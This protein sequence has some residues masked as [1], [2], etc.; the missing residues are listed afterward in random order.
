MD[1]DHDERVVSARQISRIHEYARVRFPKLKA[2]IVASR[3]CQSDGSPDLHFV[4][5]RH[6][7]FDNAW[8]AG[9]G[10]GHGFKHGPVVGE[11]MADRV[12]GRAVVPELHQFFGLAKRV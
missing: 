9:G 10:S 4:L 12:A 3:V 7:G 6:P 5:D 1:L 8:I 11:Y 2:P